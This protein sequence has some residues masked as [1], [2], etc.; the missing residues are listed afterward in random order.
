MVFMVVTPLNGW[1]SCVFVNG[2]L[3]MWGTVT[4]PGVT[5]NV[6]LPNGAF[7]SLYIPARPLDK[8]LMVNANY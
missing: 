2:I 3:V 8:P 7:C 4:C 1:L 5:V 6:F